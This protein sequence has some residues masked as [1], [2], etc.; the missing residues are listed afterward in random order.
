MIKFGKEIGEVPPSNIGNF[1]DQESLRSFF[2]RQ[3]V[4]LLAGEAA[5]VSY[6]KDKNKINKNRAKQYLFIKIIKYLNNALY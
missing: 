4:I 6:Y 2:Y 3:P 1:F 5:R